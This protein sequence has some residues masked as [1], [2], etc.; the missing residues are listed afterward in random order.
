MYRTATVNDVT[1]MMNDL[2]SFTASN[3]WNV[4]LDV[5]EG[6]SRRVTITKSSNMFVTIKQ[7][8]N[9]TAGYGTYFKY[10]IAFTVSDVAPIG[11][12]TNEMKFGLAGQIPI[13]TTLPFTYHLFS[14]VDGNA[15]H[16]AL[17]SKYVN[18]P[19]T[20]YVATAG[21]GTSILKMD[22][23]DAWFFYAQQIVD[24]SS[25]L[26]Y[27]T[28]YSIAGDNNCIM[29]SSGMGQNKPFLMVYSLSTVFYGGNQYS[30]HN[31]SSGGGSGI[32]PNQYGGQYG[33]GAYYYLMQAS[34]STA[35]ANTA[36]VPC[37]V[38]MRHPSVGFNLIG[39]IPGLW[40]SNAVPT[41]YRNG[42]NVTING[43]SYVIFKNHVRQS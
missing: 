34:S 38:F 39:A 11:S 41:L 21:F 25:I 7:C 12:F 5:I 40:G 14:T 24:A 23:V 42:A 4:I 20:E 31:G 27:S 2:V 33:V 36:L 10:G 43:L 37:Y 13:N 1:L 18:D 6:N 28:S 19:S 30:Y 29:T 16:V 8:M 9:E 26:D 32:L 15:I 35:F 22:N 17:V 3:G